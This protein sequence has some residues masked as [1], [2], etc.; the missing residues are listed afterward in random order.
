MLPLTGRCNLS[1]CFCSHNQNPPGTK[2]YSFPPLETG[3]LLE[4]IPFLD[5]NQKIVIG[6]SATRLREGEPLTHP[7][8]RT[9]LDQ[10]RCRFP[11]ALLQVTTNGSLLDD[12]RIRHLASLA[13]LEL[14]L[15]LNS[16]SRRGR[17]LLMRDP[18]PGAAA[19]AVEKLIQA[20]IPLHGSVVA[21][22]HLVGRNDLQDTLVFLNGTGAKTIRLML[23]GYTRCTDRSLV[24]PP[25]TLERCWD[26]AGQLRGSFSAPLLVEP[27]QIDN[28]EPQIEGVIAGSPAARAGLK[29]GDRILSIDGI[30]PLSRV[31]A[32]TR[33]RRGKSPIL[34]ALRN[35]NELRFELGK[36]KEEAPGFAVSYDLDPEQVERV[37]RNLV[38]GEE[39]LMLLSSAALPRWRLARELFQLEGLHL[40]SVTSQF[41]GGNISCAGL[42]T[43]SDFAYVL[44][45]ERRLHS[46]RV[47][48]PAV[49]FDSGGR[50]LQGRPYSLL[51]ET[52]TAVTLVES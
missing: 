25:G 50:D 43:V 52:G 29:A 23:P 2:A 19:Q 36:E 30:T 26:L 12:E 46:G 11:G 16:A 37:R 28:F 4:L 33:A 24:P 38:P 6:E 49:A 27:P 13:P 9:L 45:R 20:G 22:P 40:V 7:D 14:V 47:L 10:L 31:D 3:R 41:F 39:T 8:F 44:K 32:F 18:W 1:C 35:G 34:T 51:N 17:R 42:L 5:P 15:S 21:M 48:I